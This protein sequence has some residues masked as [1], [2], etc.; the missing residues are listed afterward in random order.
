MTKENTP[1][2]ITLPR[3]ARIQ[4][5]KDPI[6]KPPLRYLPDTLTS[7]R[8]SESHSAFFRVLDDLL[9]LTTAIHAMGNF[10]EWLRQID[11]ILLEFDDLFYEFSQEKID[12]RDLAERWWD[13]IT[14]PLQEFL[15]QPPSFGEDK[16]CFNPADSNDRELNGLVEDFTNLIDAK[17]EKIKVIGYEFIGAISDYHACFR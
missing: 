5:A 14:Q 12:G 10:D 6:R 16:A 13:Q 3:R 9:E 7:R 4:K 17:C 1:S 8:L 15:D 2:T 11:E